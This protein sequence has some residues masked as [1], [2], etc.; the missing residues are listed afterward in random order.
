MKRIWFSV[1]R[2]RNQELGG[3][4]VGLGALPS[5]Y[6]DHVAEWKAKIESLLED[7]SR[8]RELGSQAR[9]D[10]EKFTWVKR[11]ERVMNNFVNRSSI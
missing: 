9:K 6:R 5:P 7:E 1:K 3:G 11:Q 10:V 8:R 2:G 4:R